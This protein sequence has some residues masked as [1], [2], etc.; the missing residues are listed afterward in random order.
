MKPVI[1]FL[2]TP[3]TGTQWLAKNLGDNYSDQAIIEH[4]PIENDYYLKLNLGRYTPPLLPENNPSLSSHLDFINEIIKDKIYIEVGWQSIGGIAELYSKFG[5]HLKFIHLY[6]NP[7]KVAASMLTH[8]WYKGKVEDRFK[9]SAITPY[10]EMSLLKEYKYR[11]ANL[12]LFE[13]SLYYWTEVNLRA[14][15]IKHYFNDIPFYSLKFEELFSDKTE[16]S[17]ISMISTLSFLGL[18]FNKKMLESVNVTYDK[19]NF[20][21]QLEIDPNKISDH[22]QTIA[23]ASKLGYSFDGSINLS[24]YKDPSFFER[25]ITKLKNS[26][27]KFL[28]AYLNFNSYK[29]FSIF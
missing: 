13:K 15:E 10:D 21:T 18:G 27:K 9:K 23:L 22:P 26:S 19:Y 8:T 1:I 29:L 3:R 20:K 2:C 5:K 6:R 14:I 17:R 7:L 12:D 25:F 28:S 4:E 11:W 16:I 24:R